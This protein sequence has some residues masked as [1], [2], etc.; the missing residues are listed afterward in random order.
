MAIYIAHSNP[1]H[2]A[3]F[4]EIIRHAH[5]EEESDNNPSLLNILLIMLKRR[6]I[7]LLS[8][9]YHFHSSSHL[10]HRNYKVF[11]YAQ[12]IPR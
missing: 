9:L 4:D 2:A 10:L 7:K 12:G 8:L 6:G 11:D 1:M 5:L 3:T